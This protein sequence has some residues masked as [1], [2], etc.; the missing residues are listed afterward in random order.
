MPP[1]TTGA[2]TVAPVIGP[3]TQDPARLDAVRVVAARVP[4]LT[5]L[6]LHGSRSRGQEHA[7]SDWDLGYRGDADPATLLDA[8]A[9]ALG[10]DAVDLV[11]LDRATSLLR[12]EAARDGVA[13]YTS[14]DAY[15]DF[16][17]EATRFWCDAG[18]VIRRAQQDVL[19]GLGR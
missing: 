11:D 16:V 18:P 8:V 7:G 2:A 9:S 6:L 5:L 19:A 14:G 12:Y 13:L 1:V 17:L 4:G 10:T 3:Q 15:R